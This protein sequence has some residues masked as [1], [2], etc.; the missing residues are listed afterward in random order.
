MV[1]QKTNSKSS[2]AG[3]QKSSNIDTTLQW[4]NEYLCRVSHIHLYWLIKIEYQS[5]YTVCS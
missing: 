4:M 5:V 3:A 2:A 1:T